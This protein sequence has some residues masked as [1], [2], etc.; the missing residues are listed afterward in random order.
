M[1]IPNFEKKIHDKIFSNFLRPRADDSINFA[2]TKT[3]R[4]KIKES[5][6]KIKNQNL[7]IS[8]QMQE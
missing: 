2:V 8:N 3:S 5:E 4:L 7:V 6:K 1:L